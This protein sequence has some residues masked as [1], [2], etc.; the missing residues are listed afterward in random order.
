MPFLME[1]VYLAIGSNLGCRKSNLD[2]AC[3]AIGELEGTQLLE[4]SPFY[5]TEPV[6]GPGGQGMFL[7]GAVKIQTALQPTELLEKL[8]AIELQAGR[9][10]K[11]KRQHW[12]PRELDIDI[13]LFGQELIDLGAEL[14]VPHPRMTQRWFVL[15][16]LA[17]IAGG[18]M[19]PSKGKKISHL[20]SKLDPQ[21]SPVL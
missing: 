9:L 14:I 6:G 20:L 10:E 2:F 15:K 19:H 1:D 11:D 21:G 17:D 16:P 7:N 3:Q 5:E 13:L 8:Q 12:G 18:V 4:V